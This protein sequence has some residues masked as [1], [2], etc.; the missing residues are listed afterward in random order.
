VEVQAMSDT[1]HTIIA[2]TKELAAIIVLKEKLRRLI[3]L[4]IGSQE[5]CDQYND[6]ID[7]FE[8]EDED[9]DAK[10]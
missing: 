6:I 3:T 8:E 2:T 5:W 1:E 4:H 10:R 7:I 9:I